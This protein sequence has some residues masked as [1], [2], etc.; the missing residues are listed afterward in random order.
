M[1]SVI[2][3]FEPNVRISSYITCIFIYSLFVLFFFIIEQKH[4]T[5]VSNITLY[6]ILKN[7]K[8]ISKILP[9][10]K[11]NKRIF[12]SESMFYPVT[13][14]IIFLVLVQFC[15]LGTNCSVTSLLAE[16]P[17]HWNHNRSKNQW[18]ITN[19]FKII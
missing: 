14:H 8:I 5:N 12:P 10:L 1:Y 4:F 11:E 15:F 16:P 3:R 17:Y 9:K 7:T 2:D 6:F 13:V 19:P 18:N